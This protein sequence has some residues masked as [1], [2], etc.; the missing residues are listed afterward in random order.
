MPLSILCHC[1]KAIFDNLEKTGSLRSPVEMRT[2]GQIDE[3]ACQRQTS[4]VDCV[5]LDRKRCCSYIAW[6]R[7]RD[8]CAWPSSAY[9]KVAGAVVD[10]AGV[11]RRR[12]SCTPTVRRR[13]SRD[14]E[15]RPLQPSIPWIR[16]TDSLASLWRQL[17][18]R[19]ITKLRT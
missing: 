5:P 14:H 11:A 1:I 2:N 3:F 13:L 9:G 15:V 17:Y 18:C 4:A 10:V 19:S 6:L 12:R 8:Y 7:W 16:C